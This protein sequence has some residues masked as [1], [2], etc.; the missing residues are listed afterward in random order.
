MKHFAAMLPLIRRMKSRL[1]CAFAIP[2]LE[3]ML[4][5]RLTR[6]LQLRYFL[7]EFFNG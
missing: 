7:H 6:S 4:S 2:S 5:G 3:L 1:V